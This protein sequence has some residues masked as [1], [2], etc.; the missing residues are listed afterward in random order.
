MTRPASQD[1]GGGGGVPEAAAASRLLRRFRVV[2]GSLRAGLRTGRQ[3]GAAS[4]RPAAGA[5]PYG[6]G[7]AGG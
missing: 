7:G 3:A 1:G 2:G 6:G 5:R 4:W